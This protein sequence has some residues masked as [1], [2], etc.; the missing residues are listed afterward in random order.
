MLLL[1]YAC[2]LSRAETKVKADKTDEAKLKE[3]KEL[4]ERTSDEENN[5]E[6]KAKEDV[7]EERTRTLKE[8]TSKKPPVGYVHKLTLKWGEIFSSHFHRIFPS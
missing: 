2:E 4:W 5:N 8:S 3:E 1:Q 7:K 6:E